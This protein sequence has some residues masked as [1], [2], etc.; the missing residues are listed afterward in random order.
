MPYD[1]ELYPT[2]ADIDRAYH[3]LPKDGAWR[4]VTLAHIEELGTRIHIGCCGCGREERV[5]PRSYAE[6]HG[7]PMDTPLKLVERRIRC[8][9]CGARIVH[10]MPE[11]YSITHDRLGRS[12]E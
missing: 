4:R 7:I 8:S 11:P 12:R 9:T 2:E 10:A 5:W 3:P 1:P 6:Q